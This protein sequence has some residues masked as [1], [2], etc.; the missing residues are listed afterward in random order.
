MRIQ[1][2]M[3]REPFGAIL[4][5]TLQKFLSTETSGQATVRWYPYNPG[6]R[7][8]EFEGLQPWFG[9]QHLNFFAAKDTPWGCFDNLRREYTRATRWWKRPAQ[10]L[11]VA[12]ATSPLGYEHLADMA[13]G[14]RPGIADAGKCLILGGNTRLRLLYPYRGSTIVILKS[15]FP[16]ERIRNEIMLR[17]SY[18]ITSA[19]RLLRA[20]ASQDW[21]EEEY[22]RG[23]P[24][25]RFD[26][27][28]ELQYSREAALLLRK[29]ICEPTLSSCLVR[30]HLKEL[31]LRTSAANSAFPQSHDAGHVIAALNNLARAVSADGES[32]TTCQTHGDFQPANILASA[33]GLRFIDWESTKS[34]LAC[35]DPLVLA[36]RSRHPAGLARRLEEIM[37][38]TDHPSCTW[39]AGWPGTSK[40]KPSLQSAVIFLLEELEFFMHE[41]NDSRFKAAPALHAFISELGQATAFLQRQLDKQ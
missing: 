2:L 20:S 6:R 35:Y 28:R 32:L 1:M 29:Q 23:T 31:R 21:L 13:L 10:L 15:G 24:I 11:Y 22:I 30:N 9:N 12:A 4:E 19:P 33:T 8:I 5:E 16:P 26:D 14:V 37:S 41:S 27:A 3:Q 36:L 17:T 40:G 18:T 39:L 34:R 25:N 38:S 7:T